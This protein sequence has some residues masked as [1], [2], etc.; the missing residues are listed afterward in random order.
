MTLEEAK[1]IALYYFDFTSHSIVTNATSEEQAILIELLKMRNETRYAYGEKNPVDIISIDAKKIVTNLSSITDELIKYATNKLGHKSNDHDK[2]YRELQQTDIDYLSLAEIKAMRDQLEFLNQYRSKNSRE[3]FNIVYTD[4]LNY[5]FDK[6]IISLYPKFNNEDIKT[7]GQYI[8]DG[9]L[10]SYLSPNLCIP[11]MDDM[12]KEVKKTYNNGFIFIIKNGQYV[13][14]DN[15][16]MIIND[17]ISRRS[18][19]KI[20]IFTSLDKLFHTYS[21]NGP[22]D[23]VHDFKTINVKQIKL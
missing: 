5:E 13:L 1:D 3:I 20:S 23:N 15:L 12:C 14:D 4:Y 10:E 8:I 7:K 16:Q 18:N 11:S 17:Y 2:K 19:S 21:K 22:I 9:D 6:S